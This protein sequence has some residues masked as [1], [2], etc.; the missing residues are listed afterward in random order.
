MEIREICGKECKSLSRHTWKAHGEGVNHKPMSGK[1]H[2][3]DAIE[4]VRNSRIGKSSGMLGKSGLFVSH[5][6]ESKD[7]I[8]NSMKGNRNAN[9]RGDRQSFYKDVRMDSSWEVK[10]AE[11]LDSCDLD[12]KY[13]HRSFILSDG[14]HYYPDFFIF[15]TDGEISKIIEVKG[16]FREENKKKFKMFLDEYP[17]FVVELWDKPVL[18]ELKI[19]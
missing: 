8:S 11:Y 10:T 19:L 1:Q 17:E 13:S 14:R 2:T 15:D 7:K 9:H 16:Y 6:Q 3:K 12:W 5:T 4:K 18:K